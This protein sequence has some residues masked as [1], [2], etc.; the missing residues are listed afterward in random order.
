MSVSMSMSCSQSNNNLH[1]LSLAEKERKGYNNKIDLITNRI[2]NLQQKQRELDLRIKT[3]KHIEH[4]NYNFKQF[5]KEM[6]DELQSEK[7][8][9]NANLKVKQAHVQQCKLHRSE[10][11]KNSLYKHQ[12][13]KQQQFNESRAEH[14]FTAT[15]LSQYNNHQYNVNKC[16]IA[17]E[18]LNRMK[19]KAEKEKQKAYIADQLNQLYK[20]KIEKE[21]HET[22]KL[23]NELLEL[24]KYEEKCMQQLHQTQLY[25]NQMDNKSFNNKINPLKHSLTPTYKRNK[26]F[27]SNHKVIHK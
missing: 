26:S 24:E 10:S 1:E 11:M 13:H 9:Q 20:Y 23:K 14:V 16:K 15:M 6:N 17:K 18:K 21:K 27:T 12:H 4:Q 8:N 19:T 25:K 5:K 2:K 22:S 7:R 3:M